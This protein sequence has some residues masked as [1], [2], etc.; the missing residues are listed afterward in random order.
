M[1][2][3]V[4]FIVLPIILIAGLSLVPVS[5]QVTIK[6]DANYFNCYR[7]LTIPANWRNWYPDINRVYTGDSSLYNLR[8]TNDGT[9]L[10]IRGESF[11]IKQPGSNVLLV[12]KVKDNKEYDYSYT[13]VPDANGL[14]TTVMVT[15][16]TNMI[17]YFTP[18][19]DL[20]K[21]AV[22]DFK[23]F[24]ETP[25][26]YYGFDIAQQ[27]TNEKKII[28]KKKT[29]AAAQL[30]S[31]AA[32]MKKQLQDYI[33]LKHLT[34]TGPVMTQFNTKTGDSVQMMMGLPVDKQISADNGFL[35]MVIPPGRALTASFKGRYR[36]KKK[37][38]TA[39][40][41]YIQDKYL[42]SKIA[43]LEE[44]E[45]KFPANDSDTIAFRLISPIF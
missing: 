25:K 12:K 33:S 43:P 32:G 24:M 15:F 29:I 41:S 42:H 44:F 37:I 13:I 34:Q 22:N 28:V 18:Q 7:Q 4:L 31:E 27:F 45:S 20:N 23:R 40:A 5:K 11:L 38:Y 36:D 21:T 26:L 35:Y 1:K 39:M 6:I 2:K 3:I 19:D 17:K 8:N 10:I 16:T 9:K 30:Y 14:T